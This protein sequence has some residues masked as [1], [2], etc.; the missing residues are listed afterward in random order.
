MSVPGCA[1]L[2]RLISRSR[3]TFFVASFGLFCR[4]SSFTARASAVSAA[5]DAIV[6][7][8]NTLANTATISPLAISPRLMACDRTD[9]PYAAVMSRS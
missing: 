7:V 4:T 3:I 5:P 2:I 8:M 9:L 1:P 6:P